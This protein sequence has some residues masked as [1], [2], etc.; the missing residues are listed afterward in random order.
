M[1]FRRFL[2]KIEVTPAFL[3]LAGVALMTD[4]QNLLPSAFLAALV[5]ELGHLGVLKICGG[6]LFRFRLGAA[7]AVIE[8]DLAQL[9]YLREFLIYLA[10]PMA[11][12]LF[13]AV[14]AAWRYYLVAGVSLTLGLFN[15][16]PAG[17]L[18]GGG[19]LRCLFLR[20][21]GRE[22]WITRIVSAVTAAALF[23]ASFYGVLHGGFCLPLLLFS[24]W[25]LLGER[26]FL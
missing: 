20:V 26:T 23:C 6:K 18:D 12:L 10:G 24:A 4:T 3:L 17:A 9:S 1:K 5:H 16:L 8:T 2:Q 25:M 19:M 21:F 14:A 15:L 11:S 13:A 7:G 22:T